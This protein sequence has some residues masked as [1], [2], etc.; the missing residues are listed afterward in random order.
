VGVCEQAQTLPP[1]DIPQCFPRFALNILAAG[2]IMII[3]TERELLED[4]RGGKDGKIEL[5]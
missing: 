3:Q 5:F 1:A 4:G 2:L